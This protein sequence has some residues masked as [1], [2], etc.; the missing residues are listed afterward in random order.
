M[1]E[2]FALFFL[3]AAKFL[4]FAFLLSFHIIIII[5]W[6]MIYFFKT[7]ISI[8]TLGE[9]LRVTQKKRGKTKRRKMKLFCFLCEKWKIKFRE[10]WDL[11]LSWN[12]NKMEICF[13]S[14]DISFYI[15]ANMRIYVCVVLLHAQAIEICK[16][17]L[18]NLHFGLKNLF[19]TFQ[20][21]RCWWNFFIIE[22]I[23]INFQ[24]M[25]KSF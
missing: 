2:K 9:L 22:K 13:N 1:N 21:L 25:M 12:A 8:S 5:L 20:V 11:F 4:P 16:M 15:H 10:R 14:F 24:E 3:C 19:R 17:I 23:S 6:N 7:K 18:H